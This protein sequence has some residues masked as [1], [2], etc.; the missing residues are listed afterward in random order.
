VQRR[1]VGG[2]AVGSKARGR[3]R[4]R[5]LLRGTRVEAGE[6]CDTALG[7]GW[8]GALHWRLERVADG[9]AA[10]EAAVRGRGRGGDRE[11]GTGGR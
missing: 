1:A 6:E 3:G 11:N 10:S 4:G 5:V 8:V 7:R 9:W 2:A